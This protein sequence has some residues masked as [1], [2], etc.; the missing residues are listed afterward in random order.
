V[1]RLQTEA[2][3]AAEV[4]GWLEREGWDTFSEVTSPSGQERA[5]IVAVRT[6]PSGEKNVA[7]VECKRELTFDLLAQAKKWRPHAHFIWIAVPKAR[8]SAGRAEAFKIA[9]D[10][11]LLGVLEVDGGEVVVRAAPSPNPNVLETLRLSLSPEHK[12]HAKAGSS[13]GGQFTS[14]KATCQRLAAFVA[15]HEGCTITEA[16]DGITHHY[17]SRASAV[18]S[19]DHWIHKDRVPGVVVG[20]KRRLWTTVEAAARGMAHTRVQAA[21]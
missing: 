8:H 1:N 4:I 20:W 10:Y 19:L 17:R 21:S 5:D 7:V 18:S 12:N 9:R 13:G 3:L 15:E 2:M 16:V 6:L 11:C 14:W